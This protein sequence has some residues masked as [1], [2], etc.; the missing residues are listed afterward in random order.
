MLSTTLDRHRAGTAVVAVLTAALAVTACGSDAGPD[1]Q[2]SGPQAPA[3]AA[4]PVTITHAFG[5]TTIPSAPSRIV[6]LGKNDAEAAI[7]L[8][9]TPVATSSGLDVYPWLQEALDEAGSTA[10]AD[11]TGAPLEQ[12][13]GLAPD[14]I[15]AMD[16]V[17]A[18]EYQA[19]ADIAPTLT[20]EKDRFSYSWQEFTRYVARALGR[21]EQADT[22]V[23]ETESRV[24]ELVKAN[25]GIEGRSFSL[26]NLSAE[27][28]FVIYADD[29][30]G[31]TFFTELGMKRS[32]ELDR[33]ASGEI[34]V[35]DDYLSLEQLDL[36][37]ADVVVTSFATQQDRQ[38]FEANRVFSGMEAVRR[39]AV[40]ALDTATIGQVL[41]PSALGNVAVLE[42]VIPMLAAAAKTAG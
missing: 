34:T 28:P 24:D 26:S 30:P 21:T 14:L 32:P 25:P 37:D 23:A 11:E 5:E 13:T 2:S 18:A 8:G 17:D 33:L 3:A 42:T 22:V 19:L 15:I 7:S 4:F 10:L 1:A 41:L 6:A 20:Y 9:V 16:V 27:F 40:V 38:F 35:Q 12:I 29:S 39:G 31:V 36:L